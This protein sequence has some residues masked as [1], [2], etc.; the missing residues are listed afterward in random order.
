M[1]TSWKR[2]TGWLAGA[3]LFAFLFSQRSEAGPPREVVSLEGITEYALDN[4]CRVL[5]FPDA[6][7]N[8]ITVNLTVMV[9]SR[10][11]GYGETGMAHL[12]EHMVFKGTPD[13]PHIPRDL[14]DRGAQFNG[15]TWLDRTNYYETLP[16]SEENLRFALELEADRMVNSFIKREDLLSEMTV[17]RNE[18]E[19]GE[20]MPSRILQQR[21]MAV[22]Y[23]WH[24]YG[25]STI[26]N[27]SDIERVPIERL[28]AF[29]RKHYQPDNVLVI[30]AGNFKPEL[31][32]E[33]IQDTFGKL[34]RPDRELDATYTEEPAQDGER[35]VSL[36]RVGDVGVVGVMYHIPAGSHPDNTVCDVLCNILSTAPSGR[37][38]K[39]L[40]EASLATDV[41]TECLSLHDP[42][43]MGIEAEVRKENSLEQV[44][45]VILQVTEQVAQEGVTEEEVERAK[46]QLLKQRELEGADTTGVAV[47]LSDWAAQGDWRLYL[48][49]RDR[50]ETVTPQ[51]VQ[52][53]A[54]RYMQ[55][56]NRTVGLFIPTEKPERV[57]VPAGPNLD[58]IF[59]DYKGRQLAAQGEA[60]D[61][62]PEVIDARSQRTTLPQGIKV[63][64]LPKKTR[65]ETVELRLTLR[66]GN[67]K[68][69]QGLDIAAGVLGP[70][71]LKGTKQLSRQEVQDQLDSHKASL[72]A[73]SDPGSVTFSLQT[74]RENLSAVL[75]LLRQILR[76]PS[77]PADEF[78]ILRAQRLATLEEQRSDPRALAMNLVRRTTSPYPP[79]DV[80]Y[81]PTIDESIERVKKATLD[82]VK[83]LAE[84]F[85]SSQAGELAI[86]GD[87]D[88]AQVQPAL[89]EA[90]SGWTTD[91]PFER[92]PREYNPKFKSGKQTVET[93]DKANAM[94]MAGLPLKLRDDDADYPALLIGNFVFGGGGLSSRLTDRVR[95]RE[96]LSYGVGS[97]LQADSL[98]PRGSLVMFA[99]CNPE[100][101][102]KVE[103][104]IAEELALLLDKGITQEELDA[105]RQGFLQQQEVMRGD[106]SMLVGTLAGTVLA[107]RTMSYYT[108]LE[109][110]IQA[111]STDDVLKALR[112]HILP[113][114]LVLVTAGDFAAAAAK[115]GQEEKPEKK[116]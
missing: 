70:L 83:K 39:A 16:A 105:A 40:I 44:R 74:T 4:G 109:K 29:Y 68:N 95:Q 92:I 62:T 38:H 22:A 55:A 59:K 57:G 53:V 75:G 91:V 96:G 41:N 65:S 81:M 64:L 93:P 48:L 34:P 14:K 20:N 32:L 52:E 80:R 33:T 77:L 15:T 112:K 10:H 108:D 106:D 87:F 19:Q 107:D 2:S 61:P 78:E 42:G 28:Q 103:A 46:Q 69:L 111:L 9:G 18:F 73:Q 99:I 72:S 49:W 101:M 60:F 26:G 90:L 13:H 21:M 51:D 5:L 114:R 84:K 30:V 24:N 58:E 76:E 56:N 113:K 23:E 79:E 54:K 94:Y 97:F 116:E 88:P 47:R 12:L 67:L 50:V 25:K 85:L 66:Y 82:D 110:K 86:V 1:Q 98:D 8:T 3:L 37:L 11:E 31:A 115:A 102:A 6:S 89:A 71:M 63:V 104:A 17:V 45:D 36:R 43:V 27:R 7:R 100:N 35:V